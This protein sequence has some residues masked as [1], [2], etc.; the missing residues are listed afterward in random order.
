MWEYEADNGW[1]QYDAADSAMLESKYQAFRANQSWWPSV[2]PAH[3]AWCSLGKKRR[4]YVVNF[5]KMDQR[6]LVNSRL[7]R[8]RRVPT[9]SVACN[10]VENTK[11]IEG[12]FFEMPSAEDLEP[13]CESNKENAG[14]AH[15][16]LYSRSER[17]LPEVNAANMDSVMS[18]DGSNASEIDGY[19]APRRNSISNIL[20]DLNQHKAYEL[21]G[22]Q[23]IYQLIDRMWLQELTLQVTAELLN[24]V[25]ESANSIQKGADASATISQAF[26]RALEVKDWSQQSIKVRSSSRELIALDGG[27]EYL[28]CAVAEQFAESLQSIEPLV[29]QLSERGRVSEVKSMARRRLRHVLEEFESIGTLK[30]ANTYTLIQLGESIDD[31]EERE[32]AFTASLLQ[33]A[34]ANHEN[35]TLQRR[36]LSALP[37]RLESAGKSESTGS[38]A[39]S[40]PRYILDAMQRHITDPLV[41]TDACLALARLAEAGAN[42]AFEIAGLGGVARVLASMEAHQAEGDVQA[43]ALSAL[44]N[45]AAHSVDSKLSMAFSGQVSE[46]ILGIVEKHPGNAAVQERGPKLVGILVWTAC[47][48]AAARW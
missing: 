45:I 5:K 25:I 21:D 13:E 22:V 44:L 12:R 1:T 33:I 37:K 47:V 43:N 16:L 23:K 15:R 36:A 31:I 4:T 28:N 39:A 24:I 19:P 18:V 8:M 32:W 27:F 9:T 40:C 29:H 34:G 2:A 38:Q 20:G 10:E 7:C 14:I 35:V 17:I 6:S 3:V 41:Q 48:R 46:L 11:E 26:E 30:E 42:L